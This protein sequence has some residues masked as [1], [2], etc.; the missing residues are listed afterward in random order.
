MS[1]SRPEAVLFACYLPEQQLAWI[2]EE[3]MADIVAWLTEGSSVLV[4]IQHDSVADTESIVKAHSLPGIDIRT[5]R[6]PE[7]L[8]LDSDASSFLAAMS[9]LPGLSRVPAICWFVHTKGVTSGAHQERRDLAKGLF[10]PR[11]RRLLGLPFVRSFGPQLT[12]S[13]DP[14]LS[15]LT[16]WRRFMP[17]QDLLRPMP[18]FYTGTFFA[19]RGRDVLRFVNRGAGNGLFETP[20]SDYSDRYFA[21]RDLVHITDALRITIPAYGQL[22]G[23]VTT[24]YRRV[25]RR[26]YAT[27]LIRYL[28]P[29]VWRRPLAATRKT[30]A[31]LRRT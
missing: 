9:L 10:T 13:Y 25:R 6:V 12:I 28:W 5:V 22:E 27:S 30:F 2:V 24:G 4:G 14:D 19:L 17:G 8:V 26:E 29:A 16:S 11:A 21:E 7:R 20:I 15:S 3:L 23:N 31:L 18:Y 1:R